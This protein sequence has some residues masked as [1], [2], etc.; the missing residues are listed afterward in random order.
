MIKIN[1][2]A[3]ERKTA[4]KR[5]A[6]QTGQ[7]ITIGCSVILIATGLLV[8]WRY[9][10]L[11]QE[12]KKLDTDISAAQKEAARLH[13]IIEQVQQFEQRR[14]QLQQRVTLIEQLRRDQ[15]GPVHMLDQISRAMPP[16]LWL[17]ELKQGATP[18]EVVIVG[19]CTSIT[20]L[21]DFVT[22]LEASGYFK[23]SVEIVN[24]QTE[25]L[26]TAPGEIVTFTIR[27]QFQRPGDAPKAAAL[28]AASAK[29]G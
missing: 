21:T 19:K 22:N 6:F 5:I 13:T 16:M 7:K 29:Q 25:I 1:L 28:P 3:S 26:T 11:D 23:K 9:L 24:S 20:A 12:S 2:L 17:G 18:T 15:T 14:S 8:G 27:G 4:K 10:S